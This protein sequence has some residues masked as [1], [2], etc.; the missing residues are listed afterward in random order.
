VI[1]GE[2]LLNTDGEPENTVIF[3]NSA[4]N[5]RGVYTSAAPITRFTAGDA[6]ALAASGRELTAITAGGNVIWTRIV[7]VDVAAAL[8]L[9]DTHTVLLVNNTG[10]A[11][12]AVER[13]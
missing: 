2:S 13:Q 1:T 3:Y 6:A 10:A 12:Y 7:T 4:L 9:G 11:I 5:R 8:L